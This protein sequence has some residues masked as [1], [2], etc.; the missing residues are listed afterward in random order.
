MLTPDRKLTIVAK[1]KTP[2]QWEQGGWI[3]F[4]PNQRLRQAPQQT[5]LIINHPDIW[6]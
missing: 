4:K 3:A 1:A 6:L 2:R 5:S